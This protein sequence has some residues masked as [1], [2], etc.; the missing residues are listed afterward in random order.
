MNPSK[1]A[2]F[3]S[4]AWAV[5]AALVVA[6]TPAPATSLLTVGEFAEM[7]AAKLQ[8]TGNDHAPVSQEAALQKLSK[9][10]IKI[11]SNSA[12][13]LSAREAVSIFQQLGIT[14]QTERPEE[15]LSRDRAARLLNTF[16]DTFAARSSTSTFSGAALKTGTS[17]NV[18]LPGIEAL[19]D[20]V[21]LPK[22]KDCKDC[23]ANLGY[24]NRTCGKACGGGNKSS[25]SEP[26]P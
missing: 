3:T 7:V 2:I 14:I 4:F 19:E 1:R 26:T 15:P 24:E 23:C 13:V 25:G 9:A 10:G 20:C 11:G 22:N 18:A 8:P 21:S 16:A 17:H 6:A 12:E 5:M